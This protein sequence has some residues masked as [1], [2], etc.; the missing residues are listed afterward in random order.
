[1]LTAPVTA[2]STKA[3]RTTTTAIAAADATP[4]S[5]LLSAERY[6]VGTRILWPPVANADG[7]R[8]LR[9]VPVDS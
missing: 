7:A 9:L 3:E 8:I 2:C 4:C 1:M 6:G 5:N